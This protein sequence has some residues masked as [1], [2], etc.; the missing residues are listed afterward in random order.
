MLLTLL[1]HHAQKDQKYANSP[2]FFKTHL[3][4]LKSRYPILLPGE[5]IPPQ[6][7]L[8]L[9]FDDAYF[10]FYHEIFPLLQKYHIKAVLAVSPKYILDDCSISDRV[11]LNISHNDAMKEKIYLEKAPF[12]TWKEILEMQK[13]S[14]VEI[15][16]HSYSHVNFL[17]KGIDLR[18]EI[19]GSKKILEEKLEKEIST[20]V[21]PFGKFNNDVHQ[22][23]QNHYSY[24]MRIGS[25]YNF[26]WKNFHNLIYRICSDDL[27]SK[28][29][30][31]R[32]SRFLGYSY[33][34]LLHSL[35]KR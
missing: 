21:Y 35:R 4:F 22:M 29:Q 12:C 17:E 33:K 18:K 3:S 9:T 23:V 5:K 25:C 31:L 8:C 27:K 13:S 10:D 6:M 26:S 34:F 32:W 2:A 19:L 28:D 15:A 16:S 11:R 14:L 30:P 7:S 24:I 20:F 1:Y